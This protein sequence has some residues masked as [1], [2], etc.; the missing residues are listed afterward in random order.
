MLRS[1][2]WLLVHLPGPWLHRPTRFSPG[3]RQH[4][5]RPVAWTPAGASCMTAAP[6][7]PWPGGWELARSHH[8]LTGAYC[9]RGAAPGPLVASVH[10]LVEPAAQVPF[11]LLITTSSS[12]PSRLLVHLQL[13][14]LEGLML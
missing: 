4:P 14:L 11:L 3:T 9:R 1:T 6:C 5:L 7:P 2:G 12:T 10:Q 13:L 8:P